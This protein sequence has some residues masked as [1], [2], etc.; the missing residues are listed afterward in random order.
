MSEIN[1]QTEDQ[2]LS[3]S[4]KILRDA[5]ADPNTPED[6]RAAILEGQAKAAAKAAGGDF[7][8]NRYDHV[9]KTKQGEK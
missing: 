6:V 7:T 2:K 5:L 3:E 9:L 4:Q 8:R 1:S